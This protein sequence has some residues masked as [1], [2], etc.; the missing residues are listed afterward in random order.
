MMKAVIVYILI[1]FSDS[2]YLFS[3]SRPASPSSGIKTPFLI[4]WSPLN[5]ILRK[6]LFKALDWLFSLLFGT[7]YF[8]LKSVS[9]PSSP[10]P[11]PTPSVSGSASASSSSSSARQRRP[12]IS[13]ARLNISGRKLRL[14]S[15]E[16]EA[17][18]MSPPVSSRFHMSSSYVAPTSSVYS[19]CYSPSISS[20]QIQQGK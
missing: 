8:S 2:G 9:R 19:G 4:L 7:D 11:S 16:T 12:L 18:L 5:P 3:G 17:T 14:F 13:P 1:L 6:L 10:G 20:F 15:T